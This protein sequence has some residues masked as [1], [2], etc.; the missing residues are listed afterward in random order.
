MRETS[1][2]FVYPGCDP[3]ESVSRYVLH[4]SGGINELVLAFE[5]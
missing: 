4:I 2:E 1:N 5:R 3:N